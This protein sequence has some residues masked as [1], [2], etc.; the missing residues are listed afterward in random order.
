[1]HK[2][3]I[4]K[5]VASIVKMK[6]ALLTIFL[7]LCIQEVKAQDRLHLDR[8]TF[9]ELGFIVG[10]NYNFEDSD[11]RNYHL[12]EFGLIKSTYNNYHHPVNSSFYFSNELG[13]NTKDFVWGPKAGAYVGFWMFAVGAEAIYYTDFQQGSLR[14]APYFGIGFHQ[15]KLTVNPHIKLNNKDFLPNTGNFNITIRPFVLKK[16]K[17]D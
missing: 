4:A 16:K 8:G 11:S 6:K 15:F 12:V 5:P 7:I 1:M 9:K 3:S 10:Y 14:L 2:R 13:L 17:I